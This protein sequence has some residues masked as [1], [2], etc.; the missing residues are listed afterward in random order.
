MK[1]DWRALS[2]IGAAI[3]GTVVP[4]VAQ[5]EDMA[6]KLGTLRGAEK[7]DAVVQMVRGTLAAANT[8]TERQLAEDPDVEKATRGVIDAIVALQVIIA[9]RAAAPTR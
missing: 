5:V 3:V 6:W 1:I 8:L 9:K 2:H 4:G 7:Q